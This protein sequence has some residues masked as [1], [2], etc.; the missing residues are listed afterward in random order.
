MRKRL[1][2]QKVLEK[3]EIEDFRHLSKDKVIEFVSM[4]PTMDS[5]VAKSAIEQFPEFASM[6]KS[7]MIDYK[8]E[9]EIALKQNDDS[10]KAYYEACNRILDSLDK[11]IDNPEL[12]LNEKMLI[13]EKMQEVQKMMDE[14]DSENKKHIRDILAIASTV[15][16]AIAGMAI[17]MLGGDS[18]INLPT[19][20]D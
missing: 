19:K 17:T 4:I 3:L 9:I 7:I 15:V 11:L 16:V 5:E 14:K 6:M 2:E 20:K 8:Q 1:S 12:S 18:K 10:V 13:V